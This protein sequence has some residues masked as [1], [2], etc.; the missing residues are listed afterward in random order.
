MRD[1]EELALHSKQLH[2]YPLLLLKYTAN[3]SPFTVV[4]PFDGWLPFELQWN[5]LFPLLI[6]FY[7]LL[8]RRSSRANL[9]NPSHGCG[10]KQSGSV[11]SSFSVS[12]RAPSRRG[13]RSTRRWSGLTWM[14]VFIR[15]CGNGSCSFVEHQVNPTQVCKRWLLPFF[16]RQPFFP[17]PFWLVSSPMTE[18]EAYVY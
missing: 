9:I 8:V 11:S 12:A 6:F 17:S 4:R 15:Q 3:F 2:T 5:N 18:I 7:I 10:W 16:V 13:K 14:I 1:G